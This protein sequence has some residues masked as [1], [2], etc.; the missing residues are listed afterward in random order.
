MTNAVS[1]LAVELVAAGSGF[2]K[3]MASASASV[4][5]TANRFDQFNKAAQKAAYRG[6]ETGVA[7]ESLTASM[8]VGVGVIGMVTTGFLAFEGALLKVGIAATQTFAAFDSVMTRVESIAGASAG[9]MSDLNKEI[10]RL[11]ESSPL[12]ALQLAQGLEMLTMGGLS[13]A[14]A[15]TA[16]EPTQKLAVVANIDMAK[17]ADIATNAINQ[18]GVGAG[19]L[20]GI[21]DSMAV[22][23]TSSNTNLVQLGVA[24][25]YSA[26]AATG[27]GLSINETIGA[28]AAFANVGFKAS[29]GGTALRGSITRLLKPTA[30]AEG[31]I[32]SMSLVI[33]DAGGK[34]LP[35]S[36]ILEQLVYKQA[37]VTEVF[38]IF[39]ARA[40]G[41]MAAL[42]ANGYAS[43]DMMKAL[44]DKAGAAGGALDKMFGTQQESLE[45]KIKAAE[46]AF[47]NL[48]VQIGA[49]LEPAVASLAGSLQVLFTSMAGSRDL[50]DV[51]GM[52]VAALVVGFKA[53]TMGV[54][55]VATVIAAANAVVSIFEFTVRLLAGALGV[56]LGL[57]LLLVSPVLMVI[58][59]VRGLGSEMPLAAG[60]VDL[61]TGS[62]SML[63][64]SFGQLA[65]DSE[66]ADAAMGSLKGGLEGANGA[67][68]NALTAFQR[69]NNQMK[70]QEAAR[71]L[72]ATFVT[73]GTVLVR[74]ANSV[75]DAWDR[76]L[77]DPLNDGLRKLDAFGK[78]YIKAWSDLKDKIFPT[79]EEKPRGFDPSRKPIPTDEGGAGASS[80][81]SAMAAAQAKVSKAGGKAE[82]EAEK[83]AKAEE[84][85]QEKLADAFEAA[86]ARISRAREK[87]LVAA[88]KER[89]RLAN[90]YDPT[91][92]QHPNEIFRTAGAVE[93]FGAG[94][95][96]TSQGVSDT[97]SKLTRQDESKYLTEQIKIEDSLIEKEKIRNQLLAERLRMHNE[98]MR[99]VADGASATAAAIGAE[100]N[101]VGILVD[102]NSTQ[103]EVT[104]ATIGLMS[105]LG[106]TAKIAMDMFGV[107]AAKS[108]RVQAALNTIMA[109]TALGMG[110]MSA[111]TNP[112]AAGSYFMAA[113]TLAG[114]GIGGF[115]GASMAGN[116]TSEFVAPV[117]DSSSRD[118]AKRDMREAFKGAMEDI[119][120][121]E[122]ARRDIS[123]NYYLYDPVASSRQEI[124]AR[125]IGRQAEKA[126]R[127][128][129]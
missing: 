107:S 65:Q 32:A 126:K 101:L 55:A 70:D 71:A 53:L 6:N 38:T 117:K 79:K 129:L 67:A 16:L 89:I 120:L 28:L 3:Q 46:S 11:N 5:H 26:G 110:L 41:A 35:M 21:L 45:N 2:S 29:M 103:K 8:F 116:A 50:V 68:D 104:S 94:F 4:A 43:V 47:E 124:Q 96:G 20:Q 122:L 100:I 22:A 61:F 114:Q 84:K 98:H 86:Q 82:R 83:I 72:G 108:M 85:R 9:T 73:L 49:A 88:E 90:V 58:D 42:V 59:L 77:T 31:A 14:D 7:M 18:F 109:I 52:G 25:N 95:E 102:K 128:T 57:L 17:A 19:G 106:S 23:V 74:V 51:V 40:G 36:K 1:V 44:E 113:A 10:A 92:Y 69:L 54:H 91:Y 93:G 27:A 24:L 37:D 81:A 34:M 60:A 63:T 39:G 127:R 123:N 105:N 97:A 30:E 64:G 15:L 76:A 48:K 119:G 115:I 13:A 56:T 99:Q 118:D 125:T 75:K 33:K 111:P 112:V 121:D 66:D 12:S 87:G 78:N 80:I 62:L